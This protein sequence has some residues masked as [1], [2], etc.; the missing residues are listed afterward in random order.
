MPRIPFN[1]VNCKFFKVDWKQSPVK[2][3]C[4]YFRIIKAGRTGA[5]LGGLLLGANLV[6]SYRVVRNERDPRGRCSS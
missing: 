1:S 2:N 6:V 3:N 5:G 4:P